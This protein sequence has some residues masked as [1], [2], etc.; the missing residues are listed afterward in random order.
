[1][2]KEYFNTDDII[3]RNEKRGIPYVGKEVL[4]SKEKISA[5]E[6]KLLD[7][8]DG[9]YKEFVDRFDTEISYRK[10]LNSGFVG[11]K[12][13]AS[14]KY[15]KI[16]EYDLDS[17]NHLKLFLNICLK[18]K[19]GEYN[20][21]LRKIDELNNIKGQS[22]D[23]NLYKEEP[24]KSENSFQKHKEEAREIITKNKKPMLLRED[25]LDDKEIK[26]IKMDKKSGANAA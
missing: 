17:D 22:E 6:Q 3:K 4:D 14:K 16:I 9:V 12:T 10:D 18:E 23:K 24:S 25:I 21:L 13:L 7:N 11:Y 20:E 15:P 26:T 19:P 8:F 2:P 5:Y 1:M